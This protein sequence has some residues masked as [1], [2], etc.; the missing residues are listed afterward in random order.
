MNK[1]DESLHSTAG[2]WLYRQ[3]VSENP[4]ILTDDFKNSIYEAAKLS[5]QLETDFIWKAFEMGD[6]KGLS[7]EQ[8]INFIKFRTNTKLSDLDLD[9]I[10]PVDDN[11]VK[12]ME[13]FTNLSAGV[14]FQDFFAGRVTEYAK[15]QQNWNED[16][17]FDEKIKIGK[18]N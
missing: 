1:L 15:G 2:C 4:E 11:L 3:L 9:P 18:Y 5:V 14:E 17:V 7:K 8:L 6:I 10:F 13:W 16:H 12:E